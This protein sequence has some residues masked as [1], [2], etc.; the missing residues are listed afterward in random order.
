[1][2]EVSAA[3]ILFKQARLCYPQSCFTPSHQDTTWQR[4]T[5]TQRK[6]RVLTMSC[7]SSRC[8][9]LSPPFRLITLF[10]SCDSFRPLFTEPSLSWLSKQ[11]RIFYYD[12]IHAV[13]TADNENK[14]ELAKQLP[15]HSGSTAK[16]AP[17]TGFPLNRL[18]D[19]ASSSATHVQLSVVIRNFAPPTRVIGGLGYEPTDHG[20]RKGVAGGLYPAGFWNLIFSY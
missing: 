10:S 7:L 4:F 16:Q 17:I 20:C 11:A 1:M 12:V 18:I 5:L 19:F 14:W 8:L 15:H 9:T 6:T 2:S 3:A 13:N